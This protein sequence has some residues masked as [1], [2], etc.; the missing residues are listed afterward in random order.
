MIVDNPRMR[1]PRIWTLLATGKD[2]LG[3]SPV[4]LTWF[5]DRFDAKPMDEDWQ[6]L[7][8]ELIHKSKKLRDFVS[9]MICAPLVSQRARDAI[10]ALCPGAVQFLPFHALKGKPYFA[11]N[12]LQTA[13][14]LDFEASD[15]LRSDDTGEVFHV[16]ACAFV[17]GLSEQL[18]PLFKDPRYPSEVFVTERFARMA[19]EL[20]LTGLALSD[21]TVN[22]FYKIV[23]GIPPNVYPGII[24]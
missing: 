23:R 21:P 17:P 1:E 4:D 20:G 18:P 11:M 10:E 9:W 22:R 15:V 5:C 2:N 16:N 8:L 13:E 6:P 14:V 19:I 3:V 24:T 12:V 7:P